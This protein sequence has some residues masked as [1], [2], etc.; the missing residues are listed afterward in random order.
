MCFEHADNLLT[1]NGQ[2]SIMA[3]E[4]KAHQVLNSSIRD[5]VRADVEEE[6]DLDSIPCQHKGSPL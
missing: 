1:L 3:L 4:T 5:V 6:Q 2:Q